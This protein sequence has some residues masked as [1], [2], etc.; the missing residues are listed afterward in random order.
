[1][2]KVK[3]PFYKKWWVWLLAFIIIGA[4]ASQGAEEDKA[5]PASTEPTSVEE[6]SPEETNT[7][8]ENDNE[9]DVETTV[10]DETNESEV[11][12]ELTPQQQMF[13]DIVSL[14]DSK[15][16]FDTGS[17]TKGD[18][19]VGEYAFIQFDGSGQYFGEEDMAGNIIDNENFDS[20]GYVYVHDAGNIQTQG[21]L[22]NV[23]AF[24]TLGVS[25]AKE[26]YEIVNN[27]E[28]Y[29]DSAWYK[30]GVD[31]PAGQYVIESY[32]EG[33]VAIMSGPVGN[34]EIIDNE[35]FNGRYTVN[36]TDGQ[37]LVISSGTIAQ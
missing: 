22:V 37:Y 26:I 20:F 14:M 10:E 29:K 16:A 34:N 13:Q 17:Y 21:A 15:Q 19:P 31:I 24:E 4:L 9:S 6:E 28:N 18:I 25:S 12:V 30:V 2:E 23:E 36:V 33:Y 7:D 5:E 32:G 35:I 1:M 8:T 3:K 27:V 11:T